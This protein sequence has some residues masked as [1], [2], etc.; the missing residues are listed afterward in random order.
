NSELP[1]AARLWAE[2]GEHAERAGDG[3][4]GLC[5]GGQDKFDGDG[6]RL[7]SER[8]GNGFDGEGLLTVRFAVTS[9]LICHDLFRTLPPEG[10][11]GGPQI[12]L[13]RL[14]LQQSAVLEVGTRVDELV[15]PREEQK[16][17]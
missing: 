4:G 3:D 5:D 13:P 14:T 17:V 10:P 16:D 2:I 15:I 1:H 12:W 8:D 11:S 7:G 9:P 6:A